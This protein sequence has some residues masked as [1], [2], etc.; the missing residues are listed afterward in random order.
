MH[1]SSGV[2]NVD[3]FAETV[4][5]RVYRY[6][7]D[8]RPLTTRTVTL[9]YLTGGVRVDRWT[10]TGGSFREATPAGVVLADRRFADRS[11]TTATGRAG[12]VLRVNDTVAVR[13]AG[14][15]GFRLPTI[16]ELYRPFVVFP[17]TTQ[18]NENLAFERLRGG[19]IG[20]DLRPARG[21]RL[22]V[23]AFDNRLGGPIANVTIGPNLRQRRNVRA[24]RARRRGD[25][26]G[27][28][29]R[30]LAERELRL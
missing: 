2:D 30:G 12:A 25:A 9:S 8:V 24:I 29:R 6:G 14:Y 22:G 5:G 20:V 1:T 13:A 23:T 19:E 7:K 3:E 10:I 15:T 18:A 4:V 11:G 28:A 27:T 17:I 21:V 16:N 26:G